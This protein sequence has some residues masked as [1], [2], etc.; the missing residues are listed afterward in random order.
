MNWSQL[1]IIIEKSNNIVLSTHVNPDGDGLGSEVGMYH[2]LKSIGKDCRII[3]TSKLPE[4]YSF[5]DPDNVIEHYIDEDHNDYFKTVDIVIA[6]DIGDYKRMNQIKDKINELHIYSVSIDHHPEEEQFFDLSLVDVSAPA[7]GYMVWKY[8]TFNNYEE[9]PIVVA[10]ALY[11]ALITDTGSFKYNSTNS[12]CH[13]MAAHLLECGVKPYDIYDVVYERREMSQVKLLASVI[14]NLKFYNEG[15]FAGYIIKKEDLKSCGAT[16]RDVEGFTDFVRSIK[17]VQVSFMILEQKY[18]I[19]INLRSR[20]KY[21]I[22]DIAKYFGG[23][24]HQLAAGA[25]ISN[26]SCEDIEDKIVKLLKRK[27][28]H[29]Y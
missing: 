10:N 9:L 13:I 5:L 1:N 24:G 26:S 3:N 27:N 4:L 22:N 12:D 28:K 8:L 23:G 16:H 6:L 20:G 17:G 21:I 19:R 29:V 14:H 2:Y 18:D 25:T 11:C 15:E 7:T